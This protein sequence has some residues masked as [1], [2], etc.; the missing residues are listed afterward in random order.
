MSI[1]LIVEISSVGG[2]DRSR[3]SPRLRIPTYMITNLE[4]LDQSGYYPLL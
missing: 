4:R 2:Y 3:Y 1:S